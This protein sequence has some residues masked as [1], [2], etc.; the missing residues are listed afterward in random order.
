[1][2]LFI[3]FLNK[4]L[5]HLYIIFKLYLPISYVTRQIPKSSCA[6]RVVTSEILSKGKPRRSAMSL[7]T[8]LTFFGS[9]IFPRQGSGERYGESVSTS[10]FSTGIFLATSATS[11]AFLYVTIPEKEI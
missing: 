10:I 2:N 9:F 1:M 4:L 7:P 3:I 8:I 5:N 6:F 11:R